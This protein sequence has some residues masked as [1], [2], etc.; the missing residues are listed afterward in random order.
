MDTR[1]QA[2]RTD[3]TDRPTDRRPARPAGTGAPVA[4]L[5]YLGT[6]HVDPQRLGAALG[7]VARRH[8]ELRAGGVETIE[9]PGDGWGAVDHALKLVE[10]RGARRSAPADG[11]LLRAALHQWPNGTLL[12]VEAPGAAVDGAALPVLEREIE[13]A[14]AQES[15]RE[16]APE[17]TAAA[18]RAARERV[19]E[20]LDLATLGAEW[21]TYLDSA[22]PVDWPVRDALPADGPAPRL[23]VPV[24][25]R[26]LDALVRRAGSPGT[27]PAL[28]LFAVYGLALARYTGQRDFRVGLRVPGRAELWQWSVVA[29][30]ADV[31]P[32][33]VRAVADA[34]PPASYRDVLRSA[35]F[36]LLRQWAAPRHPEEIRTVFTD[37][38]LCASRTLSLGDAELAPAHVPR[39]SN[40]SDLTV[41]LLDPARPDG[42]LDLVLTS[43]PAVLGPDAL[44]AFGDV[45]LRT[46]HELA[47]GPADETAEETAD[48]TASAPAH[49]PAPEGQ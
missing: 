44:R 28:A 29:H 40:D 30:L 26:V 11:A 17:N 8:P 18:H 1:E 24:E 22:P 7:R 6:G 3:R 37:R 43:D 31:L 20:G 23:R 9:V 47:D 38:P 12:I 35:D 16:D 15:A 39:H 48:E 41:E 4:T 27:T 49:E 19:R 45:L 2:D 36:A 32:V 34:G 46:A 33:R 25:R 10:A 21:I 42:R 13:R 5:A 14:Y